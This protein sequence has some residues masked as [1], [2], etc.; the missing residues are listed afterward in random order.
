MPAPGSKRGYSPSAYIAPLMLMMLGGG[1][2]IEHIREIKNDT[3]LTKLLNLNIPSLSTFGDWSRRL[4]RKGLK[5]FS[6]IMDKIAINV[7][8]L[9]K[10]RGIHHSCGLHDNK[11][12]INSMPL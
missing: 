4:G 2:C 3:A 9:D 6:S 12:R 7:L 5:P 8:R 10:K 11:K 1:S